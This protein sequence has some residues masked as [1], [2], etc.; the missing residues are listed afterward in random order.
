MTRCMH[1]FYAD[2]AAQAD[3]LAATQLTV[4]AQLTGQVLHD[5]RIL[6]AEGVDVIQIPEP[7][8]LVAVRHHVR[9]T[10]TKQ[11]GVVGM[12]RERNALAGHAARGVG[13]ADV[14][15]VA[16][17]RQY[18]ANILDRNAGSVQ[19]RLNVAFGRRGDA[20]IDQCGLRRVDVVDVGLR[21]TIEE[22]PVNVQPVS[23]VAGEEDFGDF[24]VFIFPF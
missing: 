13:A 15:P 12:H 3:V 21:L 6:F 24:V 23:G 5:E 16:V 11:A 19:C 20:R 4:G 17:R 10:R 8:R 9:A 7:K 22:L 14:V 1:D 18:P 2:V